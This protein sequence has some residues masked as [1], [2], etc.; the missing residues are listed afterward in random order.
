MSSNKK[1]DMVA[2]D[3]DD[4]YDDVYEEEGKL[5]KELMRNIGMLCNKCKE[6]KSI[7]KR[8]RMELILSKSHARQTKCQIRINYDWDGK[9]ANFADLVLSFVK[10]YL[11]PCY[12]FLNDGWM[13]YD[14]SPESLLVWCTRT[15]DKNSK[16]R[17]N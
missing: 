17:T 9:E 16:K 11:F 6:Y 7:I 5:G 3:D 13:E 10:E 14:D 12:K 8:P 15:W 1:G 2:S 4:E